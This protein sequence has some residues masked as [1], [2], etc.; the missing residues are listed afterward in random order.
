MP[1]TSPEFTITVGAPARVAAS[2][3]ARKYWCIMRVSI[4]AGVRSWPLSGEP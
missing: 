3:G 2:K 4:H 1:F